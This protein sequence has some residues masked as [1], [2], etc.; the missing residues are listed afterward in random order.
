MTNPE[1]RDPSLDYPSSRPTFK[2]LLI[3]VAIVA[4]AVVVLNWSQ[5]SAFA[6]IGQ[7]ETEIEHVVGL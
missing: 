5:V 3:A 2:M 1:H 6:H 4:V 7:I